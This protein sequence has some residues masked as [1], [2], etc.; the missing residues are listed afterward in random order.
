MKKLGVLA[1]ILCMAAL[2]HAVVIGDFETGLDGWGAGWDGGAT[3]AASTT[4]GTATSGSQSLAVSSNS[5]GGYWQVQANVPVSSLDGVDA[6][7]GIT[8]DLTMIASEW[9]S[10]AWTQV[11]DKV[12]ISSDA[13]SGQIEYQGTISVVDRN[14]GAAASKDWGAWAG[15]AAKTFTV[16][17]GYYDLT[18]ASYFQ[19]LISIQLS[20]VNEGYFYFDNAQLVE[21][22]SY[23]IW[24]RFEAEDAVLEGTYDFG[25]GTGS[26]PEWINFSGDG[27]VRLQNP[28]GN[29]GTMTFNINVR[30]AGDYPIRYAVTAPGDEHWDNW[31]LNTDPDTLDPGSATGWLCREN[32]AAGYT[33][34]PAE[35]PGDFTQQ[36]WD[37]FKAAIVQ[38]PSSDGGSEYWQIIDLWGPHWN[39]S[40]QTKN[41]EMVLSLDAGKNS[42]AIQAGWGWATYDYIEL[43]LGYLPFNPLPADGGHAIIGVDTELAWDNALPD[44]DKVK[45]YFGETPD[46][47][48]ND[49]N[50]FVTAANYK[51]LLT[52]IA[53]IDDPG[54]S[55]SVTMPSLTDSQDYTWVVDGYAGADAITDDDPN[56]PGVFW[57]FLATD[58][59]P[60]VVNAGADQYQ[61]LNGDPNVAVTLDGSGTTDDGREQ[62][63]EYTW[64]QIAGPEVTIDSADSAVATVTLTELANDTEEAAGDPYVFELSVYDG[65][66]TETDQIQ[67]TLSTN[68]CLATQETEGGFYYFGDIAGPD[69]AG[70]E[71][72]DCKV[73]LYDF[74]ELALNWLGCSNLFEACP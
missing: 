31:A 42:L 38:G 14:T 18:G 55:T 72:R 23:S 27:Y 69:G 64:T 33:F 44:L 35:P 21:A 20:G 2:S 8:F 66:W 65:L 74:A 4:A 58:N 6:L 17:L 39:D 49:P 19:V 40:G 61:W 71:F 12:V 25:E 67:I 7:T 59:V 63:L 47:N 51:N 53:D 56:F 60:P 34:S 37:D 30:E 54:V 3:F 28:A 10:Q 62:A 41:D 70:D 11:A 46:P 15:D 26:D 57:T 45:V 5:S 13:A 68:S 16:D 32:Y 43:D 52:L 22:S 50:T 9:P 48:E 73:D 29:L 24:Q 36:E 1:M